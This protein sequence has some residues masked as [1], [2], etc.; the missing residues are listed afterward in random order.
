MILED[1]AHISVNFTTKLNILVNSL[2]SDFHIC[3]IGYSRP[4]NAPMKTV[5]VESDLS[6]PT[7]TY[8]MTGNVSTS[9]SYRVYNI[10][11]IY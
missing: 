9:S 6:I 10:S 5:G 8:F 3:Q 1:D 4:R 11:C 7:F 2:P